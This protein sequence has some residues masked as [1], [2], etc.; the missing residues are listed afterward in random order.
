MTEKGLK[1]ALI[2]LLK[3]E[4]L[5]S[6]AEILTLL[7]KNGKKYNKTSVY[8]ALDQLLEEDLVCRYYFN[9]AQASYELR[10]EHHTH[11]LCNKC[12]R[13]DS[14]ECDYAQPAMAKGFA[15]DHHHLTLIGVCGECGRDSA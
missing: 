3:T 11:L 10:E 8:R 15:I 13:V 7:A 4:H 2:N 5:L 6:V 9:E 14:V 12:G 1:L